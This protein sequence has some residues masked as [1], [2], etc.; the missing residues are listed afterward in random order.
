[1]RIYKVLGKKEFKVGEI[2]IIPL[3]YEDRFM[4]M[5][6]RN[7]QIYHLR[8]AKPLTEVGQEN[9]FNTVVNNLF[10][11]EQ[12][13]QLLFS[14]MKNNVC[15][16]YGGLVH[17]NWVDKNAEISFIMNTELEKN[18]FKKHINL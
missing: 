6:W 7:E 10:H 13:S 11:Q 1:M 4:I 2:S 3:R 18:Y 9:Y 16:G 5:K 14:Y 15:I 17:I 8:Q 12:P